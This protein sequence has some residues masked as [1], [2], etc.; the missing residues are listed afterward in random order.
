MKQKIFCIAALIFI[1]FSCKKDS[2]NNNN[3]PTSSTVSIEKS[4]YQSY[5]V[6]SL[7]SNYSSLNSSSYAATIDGSVS[8]TMDR[9]DSILV[10]IMPQLAVGSHSL[11][12]DLGDGEQTINFNIIQSN[13]IADP[14]QYFANYISI[15]D[16][17]ML[18]NFSIGDTLLAGSDRT[19][20][21]ADQQ[22]IQNFVSNAS[23]NFSTL[24]VAEKNQVVQFLDANKLWMD[25]FL[26]NLDGLKMIMAQLRIAPV[27]DYDLRVAQAEAN[28]LIVKREIIKKIP[29]LIGVI[30]GSC[31]FLSPAGCAVAIGLGAGY[32]I[33]EIQDLNLTIE[34]L[35]DVICFP[36]NNLLGQRPTNIQFE[37]N[38]SRDVV[39]TMDY[40]TIYNADQNSSVPL[41]RNIVGAL[42]SIKQSWNILISKLPFNLSYGPKE[43]SSISNYSTVTKRIHSNYLSVS[44]I[45]SSQV[46]VSENKIDGYFYLTF[47][48]Q[49]L[50]SNQNFSFDINYNSAKM[51]NHTY[52]VSAELI[53]LNCQNTTGTFTDPRDGNVYQTVTIGGQTWF[54]ENLRL[55]QGSSINNPSHPSSLYGKLYYWDDAMISC[56]NGWH[57]PSDSEWNNLEI[58]VGLDPALASVIGYRGNH[59][60]ALRSTSYFGTNSSCFNSL[61]SGNYSYNGGVFYNTG[62]SYWSS[63]EFNSTEVWKRVISANENGVARNYSDKQLFASSCR[64]VQ[65]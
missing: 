40:R 22:S 50:T 46:N 8:V 27:D 34:Q 1:L 11:T 9:T 23:Q 51:G 41:V 29:K 39:V 6:A 36:F 44:N 48:N 61:N 3:N 28:F 64:C 19:N 15:F 62:A 18:L 7:T 16:S 56:P 32:F 52:Q 47:S 21:I 30:Y 42:F 35:I 17:R 54:A 45:S 25:E 49:N 55:M 24:S 13:F 14:D 5:E 43:I 38:R 20:F 26:M 58:N 60:D 10:F 4:D 53:S 2:N 57:L 65:D 59:S 33:A 63:T 12:F 37:N 31:L